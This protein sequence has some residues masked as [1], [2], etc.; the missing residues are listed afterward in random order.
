MRMSFKVITFALLILIS[1]ISAGK[2]IPDSQNPVQIL[3]PTDGGSATIILKFSLSSPLK[4]SEVIGVTFASSFNLDF[5]SAGA[6]TPTLIDG[7][8]VSYK[9]NAYTSDATEKNIAFFGLFDTINPTISAGL[10]LTL[11]FGITIP[12]TPDFINSIGVFTATKEDVKRITIDSIAVLGSGAVFPDITTAATPAL[13]ITTFTKVVPSGVSGVTATDIYSTQSFDLNLTLTVNSYISSADHVIVIEYPL[14]ANISVPTGIKSYN[15]TNDATGKPLTSGTLNFTVGSD[16]ED[17]TVVALYLTGITDDLS[18]T[19]SF[20]VS[21]IGFTAGNSPTSSEITVK[22]YYKNTYILTSYSTTSTGALTTKAFPITVT[23]AHVDGWEIIRNGAWPIKFTIKA[24]TVDI[25]ALSYVVIQQKSPSATSIFSFVAS[26]CDFSDSTFNFDNS[27]SGRSN[28]YALRTNQGKDSN[29]FSKNAS[30][31]FFRLKNSLTAGNLMVIT[32]WGYAD[33]CGDNN[34]R[35]DSTS[36]LTGANDPL[37][38]ANSQSIVSSSFSFVVNIYSSIDTTST[39]ENRF[40]NLQSLASGDTTAST[41]KCWNSIVQDITSSDLKSLK[42]D[43]QVTSDKDIMFLRESSNWDITNEQNKDGC[44]GGSSNCYLADLKGKFSTFNP[45][46]LYNSSTITS[47]IINSYFSARLTVPVATSSSYDSSSKYDSVSSNVYGYQYI[48]TPYLTTAPTTGTSITAANSV[49]FLQ[50]NLQILFSGGWFSDASTNIN[51]NA[52]WG[53]DFGSNY[54]GPT[55]TQNTLSVSSRNG[56]QKTAGGG[57]SD[58]LVSVTKGTNNSFT[59]LGSTTTASEEYSFLKDATNSLV[60]GTSSTVKSSSAVTLNVYFYTSCLKWSPQ[61]LPVKSLYTY[62]DVQYRYIQVPNSNLGKSI[63]LLKLY[64][65]GGVFQDNSSTSLK[66]ASDSVAVASPKFHLNING[67]SLFNTGYTENVC[68][69][70][71]DSTSIKRMS[72]SDSTNTLALWFSG[73]SLIN[74]D[75]ATPGVTY[76]VAPLESSTLTYGLQSAA[77]ALSSKNNY[78]STYGSSSNTYSDILT[79]LLNNYNH[80]MGSIVLI[81][82]PSASSSIAGKNYLIPVLCPGFATTANTVAIVGASFAMSNYSSITLNKFFTIGA[83]P[84]YAIGNI[85]ISLKLL[86]NITNAATTTKPSLVLPRFNAFGDPSADTLTIYNY[87]FA[88]AGAGA[89]N[90]CTGFSLFVSSSITVS[91]STALKLNGNTDPSTYGVVKNSNSKYYLNSDLFTSAYLAVTASATAISAGSSTSS[92]AAYTGITKP[93][94]AQWVSGTTISGRGLVAFN[95][96]SSSPTKTTDGFYNFVANHF[97]LDF[98]GVNNSGLTVTVSAE[99]SDTTYVGDSSS[100]KITIT[101]NYALP[102]NSKIV[103]TNDGTNLLFNA[104]T[105]CGISSVSGGILNSCSITVGPP[106]QFTCTTTTS[107]ASVY[108]VYCF[109]VISGNTPGNLATV[110]ANLNLIDSSVTSLSNN[111][112]GIASAPSAYTSSPAPIAAPTTSAKIDS[113][114]YLYSNQELGLGKL[115]LQVSFPRSLVRNAQ[116]IIS[117]LPSGINVSSNIIPQCTVSTSINTFNSAQI[118]SETGDIILQSCAVDLSS[119]SITILTKDEPLIG[120]LIFS[121]KLYIN[122]WPVYTPI[123]SLTSSSPTNL[124][125]AYKSQQGSGSGVDLIAASTTLAVPTSNLN[126]VFSA[127]TIQDSSLCKLVAGTNLPGFNNLLNITVDL[128]TNKNLFNA[129]SYPNELVVYFPTKYFN[130]RFDSLLC[131]YNNNPIGCIFIDDGVLDIKFG[132]TLLSPATATSAVITITGFKAP[133]IAANTVFG[134]CALNYYNQTTGYSG[135]LIVGTVTFPQIVST[136]ATTIG[137]LKLFSYQSNADVAIVAK[138]V[139][140]IDLKVGIDTLNSVSFP[141]SLTKPTLMISF[142]NNYNLALYKITNPT[143]NVVKYTGTNTAAN[144]VTTITSGSPIAGTVGVLG[145]VVTFTF[146]ADLTI[147]ATDLFF[148]ILIS[149]IPTPSQAVVTSQFDIL[150]ANSDN[151]V[152][153]RTASNSYNFVGS[154]LNTPIDNLIQNNRGF[155]IIDAKA[156]TDTTGTQANNWNLNVYSINQ[157]INQ[158]TIK[159]GRYVAALFDT[160]YI[161]DGFSHTST[162]ITLTSGSSFSLLKSQYTYTT[163]Y[164]QGLQFYIGTTCSTLPGNY[165]INFSTNGGNF[166]S[167]A[168]VQVYVNTLSKTTLTFNTPSTVAKGSM[169]WITFSTPELTFDAL[170][171]N[172]YNSGNTLISISNSTIAS[173]KTWGAATYTDNIGNITTTQTFTISGLNSCFGAPGSIVITPSATMATVTNTTLAAS[174]FIINNFTTD[175]TVAQDAIKVSYTP[176]NANTIIRCAL[177]CS[178]N[179]LPNDTAIMTADMSN[180]NPSLQYYYDNVVDLTKK[181]FTFSNLLIGQNYILKCLLT[182]SNK[183]TTQTNVSSVI[184]ANITNTSYVSTSS[185]TPT[186]CATFSFPSSYVLTN[187]TKT[188]LIDYCQNLVAGY[189]GTAAISGLTQFGYFSNGCLVCSDATQTLLSSGLTAPMSVTCNSNLTTTTS[190]RILRFLDATTAT[191]TTPTNS[192]SFSVCVTQNPL[193]PSIGTSTVRPVD[194]LISNLQVLNSGVAFSTI[195]NIAGVSVT[196]TSSSSDATAPNATLVTINNITSTNLTYLNWFNYLPAASNSLACKWMVAPSSTAAPS[197]STVATCTSAW[198]GSVVVTP[199]GGYTGPGTLSSSNALS[200]T[201]PYSIY[202]ACYNNV[203]GATL[204]SNVANLKS[205]TTVAGSTPIDSGS[206]SGSNSSST[207]STS[208]GSSSNYL[209]Y[210][211]YALLTILALLFN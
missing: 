49:T 30:G 133:E 175:N 2:I 172:F 109:N 110:V 8:N 10:S 211:L 157:D 207:N 105:T 180:N 168:P 57:S 113:Y 82:Q 44:S 143:I 6:L 125:V 140:S 123:S 92:F 112:S 27:F 108:F 137:N 33:A 31:I 21:L 68:I 183:D 154:S 93:T 20:I 119:G 25:P 43:L 64:P 9:V 19:R 80:Y 121:K 42:R 95:C 29:D 63:R 79:T 169:A 160:S 170:N 56:L 191:V 18:P 114:S 62:I 210:S 102:N 88:S 202:Y 134:A 4:F 153:Y 117:N 101:N 150:L 181:T 176:T 167:M 198:C 11:S 208:S 200:G 81:K 37:Q 52:S 78:L 74:L 171:V 197:F 156:S 190:R 127:P 17:G 53:I 46:Y 177:A 7:S 135:N 66:I 3:N 120:G 26:T 166:N 111:L 194:T 118:S 51:C 151:T 69:I 201:T 100:V 73:L 164:L 196:G 45:S 12:V 104:E 67:D 103:L 162:S 139:S 24:G 50:G 205:F 128:S 106:I 195:L 115:Q 146:N 5:N 142:P 94:I 84:S 85:I 185:L 98:N 15:T 155:N 204:Q 149:G 59:I 28:C 48:P 174:Q 147:A 54:Q 161:P 13:Q 61:S 206:G 132:S 145:N 14:S 77:P 158:I 184:I 76:P 186:K 32:V 129:T 71:L 187:A 35:T 144:S 41:I 116:I 203:Y 39:F 96:A 189:N 23:A 99:N 83:N 55:P 209:S 34:S 60:Y 136:G 91:T 173:G 182:N 126:S 148:D 141:V 107:T 193:C 1:F 97:Y 16:P 87:N 70:E 72:T 152:V 38:P 163:A 131:I 124:G 178:N 65:Q 75:F 165:I 90:E 199:T 22:V 89:A 188:R 138:S 58:T 47:G 192:A 86:T 179:T 36:A 122:V 40:T 130:S 159:P